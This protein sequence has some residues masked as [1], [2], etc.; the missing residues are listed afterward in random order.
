MKPILLQL[1]LFSRR[2]LAHPHPPGLDY[3]I[4]ITNQPINLLSPIQLLHS[5][6]T[7][8]ALSSPFIMAAPHTSHD[9]I[10]VL[11]FGS[12]TS[13]LITRRIRDA[14]VYCELLPCTQKV[15]DWPFTPKGIILSGGPASVYDEG[16]PHADN[17][18]W[19]LGIPILGICYGLQVIYLE[20][21]GPSILC[22]IS[23]IGT[24]GCM[25]R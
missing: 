25:G 14:G 16:S 12:Q 24:I 1:G 15:K 6:C 13:H 19:T 5:Y 20:L 11:D 17:S 22:G 4:C 3:S 10:L 9:T 8:S 23:P 2:S 18:I 7:E 21:F